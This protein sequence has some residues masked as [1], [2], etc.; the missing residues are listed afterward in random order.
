MLF[1][2]F[3]ILHTIWS[4]DRFIL[5]YYPYILIFFLGG[6]YS[7]FQI[8]ALQ[9]FFFIYPV[10]LIILCIGTF[11]ITKQRI[12]RN[13][14]VLQENLLGNQLYGLTPDLMNF[15]SGSQ[16][17]AKNL[18]RNA[19]IVSRKPSI[20][21]V[22]SG[23]EFVWAP[24]DITVPYDYL[25]VMQ[26]TDT[27]TI[28][29]VDKLIE[30]YEVKYI[31]NYRAPFTYND[32]KITGVLVYLIPNTN[33]EFILQSLK[34]EGVNYFIDYQSFFENTRNVD[35]RI[36][37]PDEMINYLIENDIR[38]LMLPQLRVD[39]N[40]NSGLFIRNIHLFVWFI[41]YKYPDRFRLIHTE[42]KDE[43]CEI[44]EFLR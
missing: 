36:Y 16:W 18:D 6:I 14:P 13:L 34:N 35:H 8:K 11:S 12:E 31:I 3:V 28:L 38:Y 41:S 19:M 15:I 9:K 27:H 10:I 7:L 21:R 22:Y 17:A 44:V 2:S 23:R 32:I 5:V 40:R 26:N 20:S 39:P 42:G 4:Q 24:T 30:N 29:I 1:S 37:D 25:A 33:L 43:P